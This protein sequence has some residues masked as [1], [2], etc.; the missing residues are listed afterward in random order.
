MATFTEPNFSFNLG[1]LEDG[2]YPAQARAYDT[3]GDTGQCGPITL[4]IDRLRPIIGGNIVAVGPQIIY[5]RENG[6]IQSVAGVKTSFVISMKGGVTEAAILADER[7]FPLR[8][9]TGTNLWEGTVEVDKKGATKLAVTAKD[10]AKHVEEKIINSYDVQDFGTVYDSS[11]KKPVKDASVTLYVFDEITKSWVVWDSAS[12]GQGNSQIT[13]GQGQYS[14]L[15]PEGK[16]YL[17]VKRG[18][19]QT[20]LSEIT[21][22]KENTILNSPVNL[23]PYSKLGFSLGYLLPDTFPMQIT[24][25]SISLGPESVKT[26]KEIPAFS[27]SQT[28]GIQFTKENLKNKKYVLVFFSPWSALSIEGISQLNGNFLNP[29]NQTE[30]VAVSVQES[31]SATK[32]FMVRGLYDFFAVADYDGKYSSDMGMTT[33]PFYVFV[34]SD[35]IIKETYTG[36]LGKDQLVKK[37]NKLK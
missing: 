30:M 10:G 22:F 35:G 34:N 25:P 13:N 9:L 29:A 28:D 15:V 7:K 6:T 1:K 4:V 24:Q 11:T 5:P 36:V 32:A 20:S 16:Y 8:K 17:E 26:G 14:F 23:T 18:G 37:A 33:L 19:Y 21:E 27:F 12:Y 2:N 3:L 31:P